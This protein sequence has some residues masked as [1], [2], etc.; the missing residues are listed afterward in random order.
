MTAD[1][2]PFQVLEGAIAPDEQA[3][4]RRRRCRFR[5][6]PSEWFSPPPRPPLTMAAQPWPPSTPSSPLPPSPPLSPRP[7][8]RRGGSWSRHFPSPAAA[9]A[10][11]AAFVAAV[12]LV[13]PN[14]IP[15]AILLSYPTGC[16]TISPRYISTRTA[17]VARSSCER[18]ASSGTASRSQ[19]LTEPRAA[20]AR[21][22]APLPPASSSSSSSSTTG[23]TESARTASPAYAAACAGAP[24]TRMR[25]LVCL[26]F[27]EFAIVA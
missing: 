7:P 12:I 24:T 18:R 21:W 4:P 14:S 6:P 11:A 17:H 22:A 15:T 20:M 1:P 8:Q 3:S 13:L 16:G 5:V 2:A 27:L 9:A 19:P 26:C 23:A 10:H 25:V